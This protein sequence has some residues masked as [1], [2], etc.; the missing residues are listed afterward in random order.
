MVVVLAD[1][2]HLA[3]HLEAVLPLEPNVADI[4]IADEFSRHDI[5]PL[6]GIG[7]IQA[8]MPARLPNAWRSGYWMSRVSRDAT[9][10]RKRK[11]F[12]NRPG[13]KKPVIASGF[14]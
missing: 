7:Y 10:K 9:R 14:Q 12:C 13:T 8:L 11:C 5:L 4:D 2:P 1:R 3:P 6:R